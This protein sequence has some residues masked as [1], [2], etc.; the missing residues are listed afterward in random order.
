MNASVLLLRVAEY[1]GELYETA[2]KKGWEDYQ[3]IEC[4]L[5]E[6]RCGQTMV[7]GCL[8][9][10]IKLSSFL[11]QISE[12]GKEFFPVV[13]FRAEDW[14][15]AS[16]YSGK[17]FLVLFCCCFHWYRYRFIHGLFLKILFV[18]EQVLLFH[19]PS[20][21]PCSEMHI[22]GQVAAH[23]WEQG[24]SEEGIV[25]QFAIIFSSSIYWDISCTLQLLRQGRQSCLQWSP[26]WFLTVLLLFLV[27]LVCSPT[28]LHK[29][30]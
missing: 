24:A 2:H 30:C 27:F 16:A 28:G 3:W 5:F 21:L 7:C 11:P 29:S 4:V 17:G 1:S 8:S 23:C 26:F 14:F 25:L 12:L 20:V 22:L 19:C 15:S 6:N 18:S 9:V 10:T 13:L